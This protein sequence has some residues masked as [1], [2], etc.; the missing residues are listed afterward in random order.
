MHLNPDNT[1]TLH[2]RHKQ[3]T[4]VSPHN[5]AGR[6]I[7]SGYHF[8]KLY[9]RYRSVVKSEFC[10]NYTGCQLIHREG[11]LPDPEQK[12]YYMK[13]YCEAGEQ[14][15]GTCRRLQTKTALNLCPDFVFPDSD[16]TPDDILDKLENE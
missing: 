10:P 5:R 1:G 13:V 9:I 14:G 2:L 16:L 7:G 12:P 11:F 15:W 4:E 8:Q 3:E 6:Q